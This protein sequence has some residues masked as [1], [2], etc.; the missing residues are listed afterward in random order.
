MHRTH[1]LTMVF[2]SG[3]SYNIQGQ[4]SVYMFLLYI[5]IYHAG[6]LIITF[7]LRNTFDICLYTLTNYTKIPLCF[8]VSNVVMTF[9][10]DDL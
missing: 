8:H 2:I 6:M 4:C 9:D 5:Y 10:P 7:Y 1:L 3:S